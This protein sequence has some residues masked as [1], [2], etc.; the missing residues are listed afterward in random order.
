[1]QI[2]SSPRR[3]AAI[4]SL[5]ILLSAS[6][7]AQT[8]PV[9]GGALPQPL[10]VFPKDNWWNTDISAAP[11][12]AN[13]SSYITFIGATR[14]LHP[15]LGG[16]AG[17]GIYGMPYITVPGNQPLEPVVFDY[18]DESD[19]GPPGRPSGYP[20][21]V[22][23]RTQTKW[24]EGGLAGN[25]P[26]A[27]G[28]RHMLILD[29][30]NRILFELYAAR[31]NATSNRWEAGSGAIFPLDSNLRRPDTWTSADAAGLA[32]FPGLLRY[33]EAWG[34]S[35]IRH[36][37][38]V[39]VRATNGYVY[40]ASHRAGST[41]G[42]LPMG[43]RLR[44]KAN[45]DISGYA[46]Q[47]QRIFTAMKQYGL[48]V[49][50]NGSDMYIGGTYDTH[51]NND[52]LNPAFSSL[53]AGDFEVVQLGWKPSSPPAC[54]PPIITSQPASVTIS[55]GQSASLSVAL[56]S[57]TSVTGQ[58]YLGTANDVS[59]PISGQTGLVLNVSPGATT[60]YWGRFQNACGSY[61]SN[62]VTVAVNVPSSSFL[63]SPNPAEVCDGS[64]LAA[65]SIIWSFPTAL[66]VEIHLG[67]PSGP[68]FSR[69]SSNGS[70]Q[71][72]KWV[73]DGLTFYAQNVTGGL[74]LTGANTLATLVARVGCSG[75]SFTIAPAPGAVCDS[76]GLAVMTLAWNFSSAQT[77]EIR[78]GS[79]NGPLFARGGSGGSAQ[80]GKWVTQGMK[81]YAQNVTGGLPLTGANTLGTVTA[82]LGCVTASPNPIKVC[83]GSGLGTST[84]S[85]SYP[86][87]Q[88]VELHLATPNG[89]IFS[90]GGAAGNA[91]T[92][93]W[94]RDGITFFAQ[95]VSGGLPL[96]SANTLGSTTVTVTSAGCP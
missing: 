75:S 62:T 12:D 79:A 81:F 61:D 2:G 90:R 22:E 84:L 66:I 48:I 1:M 32:I 35:P 11:L 38:R 24:I 7:L 29:R 19:Y 18:A 93:K 28:D 86:G 74:P 67:S 69:G 36:A 4:V 47:V 44:L 85:W 9:R 53:K 80:T 68:L 94:V 21:P 92:G 77:V 58:W 60:S 43:A 63:A 34:S 54:P 26:T 59:S 16:D 5:L 50:D 65:Q 82:T 10:P 39:T 87:T 70:A 8:G 49:A 78:V 42:A 95:N 64:G 57:S 83:D 72:G 51:W 76:S 20:I 88:I 25:D 56:S 52:I 40:P 3:L 89:P 15:D 37:L 6:A 14:G 46:P 30:D 96:N 27:S 31:W 71:T 55:P 45:K 13:S 33:D 17:S 23:A 41:S 73:S 91:T